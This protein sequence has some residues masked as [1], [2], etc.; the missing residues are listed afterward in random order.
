M[1]VSLNSIFKLHKELGYVNFSDVVEE[2]SGHKL[3]AI[4]IKDPND[5]ELIEELGKSLAAYTKYATSQG[6]RFHGNRI[7]DVGKN[8]ENSIMQAIDKTVIK[9]E[10]LGRMGYPDFKLTQTSGNVSFLEI[11]VSG[12]KDSDSSSLRTFYYSSPAKIDSDARHLLLQVKMEEETSK[13]WK[14]LSW[15]LRDLISLK[16]QLKTEFNAGSR[17]IS[18]T[19]LLKQGTSNQ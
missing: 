8:F 10:K 11:K 7:N 6:A 9:I 4:D 5:K 17:E 15:E 1:T 14:V 2:S 13:Y 19:N 3:L 16:V 18:A 12:A